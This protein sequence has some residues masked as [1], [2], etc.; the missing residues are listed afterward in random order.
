MTSLLTNNLSF[1]IFSEENRNLS[2]RTLLPLLMLNSANFQVGIV[3]NMLLYYKIWFQG[4]QIKG[5]TVLAES[6]FHKPA[7]SQA[8]G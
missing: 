7:F 6:Q 1:H 3:I 5:G 2:I 4:R 8:L